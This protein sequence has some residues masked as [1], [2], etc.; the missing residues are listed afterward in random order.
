[1]RKMENS[2]TKIRS[3]KTYL[4]T[5]TKAF[6]II[7]AIGLSHVTFIRLRYNPSRTFIMKG[8]QTLTKA[9]TAFIEINHHVMSVLESINVV[10]YKY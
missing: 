10:H 4:V 9:F 2:S 3:E 7:F 5:R 1:M 6:S 8:C